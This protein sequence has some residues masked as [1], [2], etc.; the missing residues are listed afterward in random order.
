MTGPRAA[1]VLLVAGLLLIAAM[2]LDARR[3]AAVPRDHPA[4]LTGGCS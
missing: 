3:D 2:A 4:R 1:L